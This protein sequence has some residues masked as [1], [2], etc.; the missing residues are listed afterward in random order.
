MTIPSTFSDVLIEGNTIGVGAGQSSGTPVYFG[1]G[2]SASLQDGYIIYTNADCRI[3]N[4]YISGAVTQANTFM[5]GLSSC[6]CQVRGNTFVRESAS[7]T[8]YIISSGVN[9][10]IITDNIF[11]GYTVDGSTSQDVSPLAVGLTSA[12][13]YA[14]N[15]NQVGYAIIPLGT[16]KPTI[17]HLN[18]PVA[19]A[20]SVFNS[21]DVPLT[22][23]NDVFTTSGY[24]Y[25]MM[26]MKIFDTETV[27]TS[28]KFTTSVDITS[29]VPY[30]AK[31]IDVKCSIFN[32]SGGTVLLT[33][34]NSFTLSL[35]KSR[36]HTQSIDIV[37]HPSTG[38]L[39][40]VYN[41]ELL[42]T[43]GA[44][45]TTTTGSELFPAAQVIEIPT[46]NYTGT[47]I[48]GTAGSVS[49]QDVSS[50][51][52]VSSDGNIIANLAFTYQAASTGTAATPLL[53]IS[54]IVVTYVF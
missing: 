1:Y 51:Y 20:F 2:A 34:N 53:L 45:F 33:A 40:G 18:A 52:V 6:S 47:V 25:D 13:R 42:Y 32:A 15:K 24:L 27:P 49:N 36:N 8:A 21:T 9:D 28:Q 10:Q 29:S 54:P 19:N 50:N 44:S 14:N 31:I 23:S 39:I 35:S 46:L 41:W 22:A 5:L 7:I 12:S 17:F 26:V 11:D 48:S 43:T 4:N 3:S 16:N 37:S 30:G 38:I